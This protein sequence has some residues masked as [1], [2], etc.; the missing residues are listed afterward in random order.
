MKNRDKCKGH[1]ACT[2]YHLP[3]GRYNLVNGI[4]DNQRVIREVDVW[5]KRNK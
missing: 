4:V 2:Q 5:I 3:G 1:F